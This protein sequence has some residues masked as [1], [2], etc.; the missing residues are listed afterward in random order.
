[1]IRGLQSFS[2]EGKV[3]LVTGAG[4][5]IGNGIC[6]EYAGAGANVALADINPDTLDA[7]ASEVKRIGRNSLPV[8]TNVTKGDEVARLV[9]R[10]V[11]KLVESI[12]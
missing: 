6:L 4:S 10:T 11:G 7:V 8:V 2:L 3:A 5:G 12:F 1:M 9:S